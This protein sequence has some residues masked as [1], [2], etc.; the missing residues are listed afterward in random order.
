MPFTK[1]QIISL[2][3]TCLGKGPITTIPSAGEF[4]SAVENFFDVLFPS[5]IA[6]HEWRFAT[7]LA[8]LNLTVP[9]PIVDKWN[10]IYQLPGDYLTLIRLYD[11]TLDFQIFGDKLYTNATQPL[12][13]E[14]RYLPD[15]TSLPA[16]YVEY[17]AYLLAEK[18]AI[19]IAN[20]ENYAQVYAKMVQQALGSALATDAKAHPNY[21]MQDFY[22]I[23]VR[24]GR[25][26]R[27]T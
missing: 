19:G 6:R 22:Y 10:Y 18:F 7:K 4:A 11:H 3:L 13:L 9:T 17:F 27:Y 24:G 15:V 8:Q 1:T 14:Y 5:D 2:A 20:Q 26:Q 23:N 12:Y 21:G 16:Y 25:V